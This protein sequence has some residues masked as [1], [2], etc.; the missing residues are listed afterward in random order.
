[1]KTLYS[2]VV[3]LLLVAASPVANS[4]GIV[5][6]AIRMLKSVHEHPLP[7]TAEPTANQEWGAAEVNTGEETHVIEYIMVRRV[8]FSLVGFRVNE[9]RIKS[10]TWERVHVPNLHDT[11]IT[12][13]PIAIVADPDK[14]WLV[15]GA[16]A[17][18]YVAEKL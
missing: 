11:E 4:E 17:T 1:M 8:D 18:V 13:T 3:G 5:D 9:Y 2:A 7:K 12:S 14:D 16:V 15:N 6:D 10:P